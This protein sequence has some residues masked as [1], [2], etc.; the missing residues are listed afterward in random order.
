MPKYALGVDQTGLQGQA[1]RCPDKQSPYK[2]SKRKVKMS[3]VFL[4]L[5]DLIKSN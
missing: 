3:K 4:R 2:K 5:L 1:G